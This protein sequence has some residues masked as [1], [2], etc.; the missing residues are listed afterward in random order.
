VKQSTG[1]WTFSGEVNILQRNAPSQYRL[2]PHWNRQFLVISSDRSQH[3]SAIRQ[4]LE[5]WYDLADADFKPVFSFTSI[6]GEERF[7]LGVGRT[8]REEPKT[9]NTDQTEVIDVELD[10]HFVGVGLNQ[11]AEYLGVYER[12]RDESKFILQKAFQGPGRGKPI[13]P[14]EF[15][16][17]ADPFS[18]IANEKLL[19]LAI[20]G[21]KRIAKGRDV[22]SKEWLK[23]IL[24]NVNNTPE[25]RTLL[26]LLAR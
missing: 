20:S 17:L 14:D 22:D 25:K 23:S 26:D 6:G 8:I 15:A 2:V 4:V 19:A 11:E 10:V 9:W 12:R 24:N 21:L 13:S 7:G 18:G 5:D 3:G 1:D 16:S